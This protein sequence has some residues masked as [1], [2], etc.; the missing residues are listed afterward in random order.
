MKLSLKKCI[1]LFV[2]AVFLF[3]QMTESFPEDYKLSQDPKLEKPKESFEK[4]LYFFDKANRDMDK[5]PGE[6]MKLF[7]HAEDYFRT[8]EFLYKDIGERENIDTSREVAEANRQYRATHVL[9]GKARIK[10]K[11]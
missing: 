1:F 5:R 9:Y 3:A 4:A 7:E 6:A 8:A 11:K 2:T 10:A